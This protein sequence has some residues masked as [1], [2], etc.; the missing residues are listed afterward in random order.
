MTTKSDVYS[1]GVVLL[2]LLTG[3]KAMDNMRPKR[4]QSLVAW[5]RPLLR[6]LS[7]INRVIDPRL[8]GQFPCKAARRVAALAHKCLSH[9][10]S[11]RPKM[12]EVV[13]LLECLQD[14]DIA[15]TGPI[16]YVVADE[17]DTNEDDGDDR[18]KQSS[19]FFLHSKFAGRTEAYEH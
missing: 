6:D 5:A 10:A 1:F 13:K 12:G 7:M 17:T 19:C 11:Q 4:E 3:K 15:I 8:E 18:G 2:E 14:S 9:G 16:V